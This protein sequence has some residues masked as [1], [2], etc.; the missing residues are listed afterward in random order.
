MDG[1]GIFQHLEEI[2]DF[3]FLLQ[4]QE[5]RYEVSKRND[6]IFVAERLVDLGEVVLLLKLEEKLIS[7]S[8]IVFMQLRLDIFSIF[9]QSS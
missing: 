6:R 7:I 3:I 5:R 4:R 1:R 9:R 2:N 8:E